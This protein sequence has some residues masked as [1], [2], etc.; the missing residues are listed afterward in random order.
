MALI[1][2]RG[3]WDIDRWF[4]DDDWMNWPSFQLMKMPE[5]PKMDVYEKDGKVVVKAE[6]PGFTREQIDARIKDGVLTIE[7]KSEHQK[8]E[9]DKKKGYLRKE[10]RHGYVKRAVALPEIEEDKAEA[11]FENGVL[12]IIAP[13][14]APQLRQPKPR[15]WK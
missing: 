11:E 12:K 15:S 10:I 7:A 9:E 6:L 4:D 1:P 14:A 2:Y 3:G 5:A 13:K 8:E